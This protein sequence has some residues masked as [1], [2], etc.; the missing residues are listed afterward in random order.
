[1]WKGEEEQEGK[2]HECHREICLVPLKH[3]LVCHA[4][5]HS[6]FPGCATSSL[7]PESDG[8]ARNAV[9]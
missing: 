4:H 2:S 5:H 7:L 1:M 9:Q 3:L 8:A 6:V